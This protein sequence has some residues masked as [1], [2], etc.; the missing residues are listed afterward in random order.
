M[1]DCKVESLRLPVLTA[2][3]GDSDLIRFSKFLEHLY[4]QFRRKNGSSIRQELFMNSVVEKK[5]SK[6]ASSTEKELIRRSGIACVNFD[7]LSVMKGRN[8]F[9]FLYYGNGTKMYINIKTDRVTGI[10]GAS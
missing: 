6:K 1:K 7:S 4:E 5:S 10:V 2:V 8:N 9:P 3:V